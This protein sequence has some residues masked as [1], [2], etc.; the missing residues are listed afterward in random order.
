MGHM[1]SELSKISRSPVSI[2]ISI[3]HRTCSIFFN[4]TNLGNSGI[5]KFLINELEASE[6]VGQRV[7]VIGH[8]LSGGGS[9][10]N[11]PTALFSSIVKR[12]SPATIAGVFNGHT[13]K[14][15]Q[16]INYDNKATNSTIKNTTNIDYNAPLN[17]AWVG[18]PIAPRTNYNARYS[19]YQVDS[20]TFS[21][22]NS[23]TYFANISNS[24]AWTELKWELECD[25]RIT[26]DPWNKWPAIALMNA[27][28]W[29]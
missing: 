9:S 23:Q 1:L 8:V 12:F 22:V 26:Y 19:V 14:D 20:K 21:V 10:M 27:T 15:S 17:I 29:D 4:Y 5:L 24:L 16:L 28:F 3:I 7:W 6:R 2:Q 18:P 25:T 13:H 11:N